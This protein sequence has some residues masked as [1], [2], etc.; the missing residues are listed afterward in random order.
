MAWF[1]VLQFVLMFIVFSS[2]ILVHVLMFKKFILDK[3]EIMTTTP[4][5][6]HE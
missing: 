4:K 3:G 1:E 5:G 6:E 2:F